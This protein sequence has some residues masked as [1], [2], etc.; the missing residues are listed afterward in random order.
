MQKKARAGAGCE[1]GCIACLAI[2]GSE[3][4]ACALNARAAGLA[5]RQVAS[6]VLPHMI[7][8]DRKRH[9]CAAKSARACR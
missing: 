8:K 3:Q 4:H 1:P 5:M 6:R 2:H 9:A 7:P